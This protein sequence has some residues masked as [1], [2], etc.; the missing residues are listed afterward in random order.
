MVDVI[1]IIYGIN[2]RYLSSDVDSG[3]LAIRG[4]SSRLTPLTLASLRTRLNGVAIAST[5]S[6][7]RPLP[8]AFNCA[9]SSHRI[10]NE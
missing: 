4:G 9:V 3:R 7:N 1:T 8:C 5:S 10:C 6:T 2:A